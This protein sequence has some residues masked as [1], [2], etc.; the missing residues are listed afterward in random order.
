MYQIELKGSG[1]PSTHPALNH[2][3]TLRFTMAE[4]CWA[5]MTVGRP[6]KLAVKQYHGW[7]HEVAF[8][9]N[10]VKASLAY[11]SS[12]SGSN[13]IYHSDLF[14]AL[15][16][17]EK[18]G[19]NYFLGMVFIKLC[20][21]KL[22]N[23]PWLIHLDTMKRNQALILLKSRSAPDLLGYDNIASKWHVLE[24]KGSNRTLS[25]ARLTKAK[26]QA[27]QAIKVNT[28]LCS[29]HIG[30]LLHRVK[31]Q[32]ELAYTWKDPKP[33]N[34]KV[35]ELETNADT[36][37]NYYALPWHIHK[38]QKTRSVQSSINGLGFDLMID[39]ELE[40]LLKK[41]FG[42]QTRSKEDTFY[43]SLKQIQLKNDGLIFKITDGNELLEAK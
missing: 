38:S 11:K 39:K 19:V 37:R 12:S 42:K 27:K 30:G 34:D 22:L 41:L 3:Q 13:K 24:A 1:F 36:W 33:D 21:A 20:A 25:N 14:N 40:V 35:F 28:S 15:D 7:E 29:L 32:S 16:P 26:N 2:S 5:A 23:T 18:G 6:N 31:K 8:R 43:N 17:T 10:M 4:L 9:W